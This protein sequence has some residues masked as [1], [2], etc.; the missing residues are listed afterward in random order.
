[1]KYLVLILFALVPNIGFSEE[2]WVASIGT[3]SQWAS[4]PCKDYW[5]TNVCGTDKDYSD[6]GSLPPIVSVGDTITY[7]GKD[8]NR[9]RFVIRHINFFVFGKDV[10]FNSGGKRLTAKK[11]ETSC[12]LYDAM[13]REETR[14]T[15]YPSKIVI[16][17]CR[18]LR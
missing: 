11:G 5:V 6:S 4:F 15:K 8:G 3:S 10:D 9:K 13:S 1:M 14:D 7:S 16:K 17:D 12:I 2:S 18:V